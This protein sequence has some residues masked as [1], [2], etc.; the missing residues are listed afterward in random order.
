MAD[1]KL[2]RP[3]RLTDYPDGGGLSTATEVVD[4]QVN[5]LFDDITRLD[6]VNGALS[7][8]KVFA[9]ST[10]ADAALYAGVHAIIQAPPADPRVSA[11]MFET[12]V[13]G[14][15]RID[16]QAQ[17]E[18]Y[19]DESVISRM[20][21]YDRQLAGQRTV[22]VFQRPELT[23]PEIG[24][25]YALKNDGTGLTEFFR[26]S[27]LDHLVETYTDGNGDFQVRVITLTISQPL[28]NEWPGSQPNRFFT[29]VST[30]VRKTIASDAARY[31]GVTALA[32]DA[33]IGDLTIK[34]DS[35]FT[36]LIPSTLDEIPVSD[37]RPA[38][39]I[40]PIAASATTVTAGPFVNLDTQ[41]YFATPLVP[42]SFQHSI[43]G[44]L[45]NIDD[46]FGNI[47]DASTKAITGSI[48]YFNAKVIVTTSIGFGNGGNPGYI[49]YQPAG[50][51]SGSSLSTQVVVDISNRGYVYVIQLNPLPAPGTVVVSYRALGTWIELNDDGAGALRGE[52]GTG[53]GSINYGTGTV[54]VT[55]GALPDTGSAILTSW[56]TPAALEILAGDVNIKVPATSFTLSAGNC[57]PGSLTITWLAGVTTKTATDNGTGG[58]TGDATGIVIY[59]TGEV[60][61]RPT[62]LA[63]ANAVFNCTYTAGAIQEELFNPTLSGGNI[64]LNAGHAP[65]QPGSI[66]ISYLGQVFLEGGLY[67]KTQVLTDDGSGGLVDDTGT[68]IAGSVVNY[69]TGQI[70]WAPLFFAD[71]SSTVRSQFSVPIPSLTAGTSGAF[72]IIGFADLWPSHNSNASVGMAFNNGSQVVLWYKEA[73]TTNVSTTE[74]HNAPPLT[75]DLTPLVTDSIVPSSLSFEFGGFTYYDRSGSLFHS[76]N[77]F[78]GAGTPAGTINYTTGVA[79]ITARA[80]NVAP[81]F[82]LLSCLGQIGQLPLAVVHGRTPGSPLRPSTFFIQANRYSDGVL[83]T[84]LADNNGNIDNAD[85]HG[86]VDV[87]T[88]VFA[89]A[90]GKYVLDSS[91]T[92]DEKAESWYDAGNVDGTGHIWWPHEVIPGTVTFNCVVQTSLPLDIAIIKVNPVRL[93]IDGRV[94]AIRAGDTLVIHDELVDTMPNPLSAGQV[95]TLS[96]LGAAS[97]ALYDTNGLGIPSTFYTYDSTT[98]DIT[99]A[100][101]LDLTAYVQPLVAIH[102]IEDMVLCIDVQ[103]TGDLIL[104]QALT[105]GYTAGHSLVSAALIVDGD[106][107][108]QARYSYLFAQN[109]WTNVWS[110]ILI[111]ASPTSG[112]RFN[113]ATYPIVLLN[114]DCIK[115]R[116]AL[117]FTGSTTYNIVGEEL[118]VIGTGTI[119]A[120][121][122]P[123]NPATGN[124]YFTMPHA[125]FGAGWAISNVIRFDTYAAG[126]PVWVARTV[127]S[128]PAT[129]LNDL[130]RI[131]LRWDKD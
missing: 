113:D 121:A 65:I 43:A 87:T 35:V 112:A 64:V 55:L 56:G 54:V 46:G 94:Q 26:I 100:T 127:R 114:R 50:A 63:N 79:T 90:F 96:R 97:V 70:T 130:I 109:T 22:L 103:I 20:I 42:G 95:V 49:T 76:L 38:G 105:H 44:V 119:S 37:A 124:P 111:G 40:T 34:V 29:N 36:Q 31:K 60:L 126:G 52:T 58:F 39:V 59:S 80:G 110:D 12:Q 115:Q 106:G 48:D 25:V 86:V 23:L 62:L 74:G 108:A 8:R 82:S 30:V 120:D 28:Q 91:L 10:T 84:G 24:Q 15:E 92:T 21:P 83:I 6:R 71:A 125:G 13:W 68:A 33:S 1:L 104:G 107:N 51:F 99:F 2:L 47:V 101:P 3:Q 66:K 57:E 17:V 123:N 116:W 122:A 53:V 14:D 81:A 45:Q 9:Q 32:H 131:Q 67:Q 4:G 72:D 85:M 16:A 5:N 117:I 77:A 78:T 128:G 88:G 102:S 98:S 7:L 129:D 61:L 41:V 75:L 93:P 27:N 118:G 89:V 19:L 11:V 18:R 69:T 73:S